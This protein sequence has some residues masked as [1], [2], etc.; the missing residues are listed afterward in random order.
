M[1]RNEN[2]SFEAY[3]ARRAKSNHE[4]DQ[5]NATSRSGNLPSARSRRPSRQSSGI[6]GIASSARRG[7]GTDIAAAAAAKRVT[8][9]RIA[10]HEHHLAHMAARKSKRA[11]Q[12][13]A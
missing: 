1:Q 9:D 13:A 6:K 10:T 7:M 3:R 12:A 2:E 11:A 8:N 4:R 5:L